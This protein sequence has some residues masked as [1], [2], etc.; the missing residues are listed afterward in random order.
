MSHRLRFRTAAL[1]TVLGAASASGDAFV[2]NPS[3]ESNYNETWP[4]YGAVDDWSGSSGVNDSSGPFHNGGTAVPDRERVGFKQGVGDVTQDI[5]GLISGETYW[6]QFFYD[7][8]TGGGASESLVVKINDTEIGRVADLK[9]SINKS[10]HFMSAPFTAPGDTATLRFS[11]GVAGDRTLLLDD[12]TVVARSTNDIVLRNPS[13]E[14][15]GKLPAVGVLTSLGGWAQTG[16][17]G[18]DDGSGGYANNGTIPDQDLAAFIEGPGSLSQPLEGLV[19]GN[20]YEIRLSVNARTGN[21]P[22]LQLKVGDAMIKDQPVT[23]GSYQAISAKFTATATDTTLTIAQ[24]KD[25]SDALLLDDVRLLGVARKPLPPM[26]FGP[27]A[28]EIAPGDVANYSLTVPAEALASGPVDIKIASSNAKAASLVN[29][30]TDG[31]LTLHFVPGSVATEPV[32]LSFSLLAN[33]RGQSGIN[34]IEA[35]KIPFVSTPSVNVVGSLVKNASFES[36]PAGASPGYGDILGW[37]H[38]GQTGLNRT[39]NATNPANPFGDNGLVPDREQVAFIQGP[40]SLSQQITG[41]TPGRSYWLQFYYN[42]RNCCGDRKVAFTAKFDGKTLLEDADLK[43]RADSGETT[44]YFASLP[45]TPASSS[46]LL[47]FA[48]TVTGDASMVIDAV[49]IVPRAAGEIVIRN[50]SF[51]ASG[52]PPGV[53]YVAPLSIAG[54]EG[55]GAG[56]GINVDGEGPFTDNGDVPDQDRA[57]FLQNPGTSVSQTVSGLTPGQK[58]TLVFSVNG[59]NCCGGAIPIAKASIN[60]EALF[61]GETPKVGGS[62]PYSVKYLTFTAAST[63]ASVKLELAGPA[64][65]D[66]SLL[67]DDVHIVPGQRVPPVIT[68]SPTDTSVNGGDTIDL[69]AAATGSNLTYEWRINGVALRDGGRISGANSPKLKVT[70]AKAT[71]AGTYTVAVSDGLGVIGSEPAIVDVTD[72]S[73]RIIIN[74]VGTSLNITSD[75]QP[76]PAGFVFQVA[77][78]VLGPWA[79]QPGV[80]TPVSISLGNESARFLRAVKP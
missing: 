56:R 57:A 14:A 10:Y 2:R 3:F 50:P 65:S 42:A 19:I 70:G 66:V 28:A 67:L 9:P 34:V 60:D 62:N 43:S 48:S 29:A 59:R 77:P 76:L 52:S 72:T 1:L 37:Q 24:T 80:N 5:S 6:L 20:Q 17:V 40:G 26:S 7:G 71:D 23:P 11:H 39:D 36:N 25:G 8:R 21:T 22:R 47:V 45:F 61:E 12:V 33:N 13:F 74:L 63:E 64:G 18:V 78:S 32:T 35:A 54:W 38:T 49:S 69:T 53:G 4:H 15:S 51:E 58:Y 79:D 68:S 30:A 41:L 75:P 46:G 16:T 55:N 73:P 44:Y 27:L 31:S